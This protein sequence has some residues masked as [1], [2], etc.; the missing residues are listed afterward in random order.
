MTR[1]RSSLTLAMFVIAMLVSLR[2]P[3]WG[4]GLVCC[5]LFVY[6]RPEAPGS[7]PEDAGPVAA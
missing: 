1:T 6:L 3:S 2:F 7:D 4:F 5:V